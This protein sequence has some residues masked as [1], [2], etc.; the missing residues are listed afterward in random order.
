MTGFTIPDRDVAAFEV[1][2]SQIYELDLQV[3]ARNSGKTVAGCAV[4]AQGSPDMTVHV[5]AGV[6]SAPGAQPVSVAAGNL[7]VTTAD[8]TLWRVDL[9]TVSSAGVKTYTAGTAAA[10]GA[11][12]PPALPGGHL[13]LAFLT[14]PPTATAIGS[15]QIVD[16][17]ALAVAVPDIEF[18]VADYGAVLDDAT[19]DTVAVQAA[20][21]ACF[22]AGGGTVVVPGRCLIAG[23]LQDTGTYNSQLEIPYNAGSA[24]WIAIRFRGTR[25]GGNYLQGMSTL[26]S[27]WNGT[28]SGNPSIISAGAHNSV[29]P[30]GV[31]AIF[32]NIGIEAHEDPK[33]TAVDM[34]N[35]KGVLWTNLS[36]Y[37]TRAAAF[38]IP[39][40]WAIPTHSNAVGMDMPWGSN[41][42]PVDGVGVLHTTGYY[43]GLQPSEQASIA[44]VD[45]MFCAEGVRFRGQVGATANLRHMCHISRLASY[46]NP[47]ALVFSGDERWVTIDSADLEHS[48]APFT[49]V[50]D[51]DDASNYGRGFIAWHT[52]DWTTGPEDNLLTNGGT[53]LS[54]FGAYAKRWKL[55]SVVEIP[56]GTDPGTNPATGGRLYAASAT[57]HPS[58]RNSAGVVTDL[59]GGLADHGVITYLDGT[60]AAAPGT[61][62]SGKLR[63]YAKTGKVLAVLDDTG[64]ETVLGAAGSSGVTVDDEGTP[65]ATAGTTL[66]F[67]GA[68]VTASGTG[69]TKTITIPGGG[70]GTTVTTAEASMSGSNQTVTSEADIAGATLSATPAA[71]EVWI[72]D[73]YIDL[74]LASADGYGSRMLCDFDGSD[75]SGSYVRANVNGRWVGTYRWRISGV[76]AAAHTVKL[77]AKRDGGSATVTVYQEGQT[78]IVLTRLA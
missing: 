2:Q 6:L 61:P 57:G 25:V 74:G 75:Q 26:H 53:G 69:A 33:L 52:T 11:V 71:T 30:N 67:V 36:L 43:T 70:G 64:A 59:L 19:D 58:W 60:V 40:P 3:L 77:R 51:I 68:G 35:A 45:V 23:A 12:K 46:W 41:A 9:V 22:A 16:K 34:T 14:V 37:V 18:N 63:V 8:A 62:A 39:C 50:Y 54:L 15:D 72:V 24:G 28:I 17:R 13:V 32:D 20:I 47:R 55:N 27:T 38:T 44:G 76:S 1:P 4:T 42:Q 29:S 5:A 56:T 10:I 21:N 65:L 48:L 73:G 7:S 31:I 66:D 49:A 78:K